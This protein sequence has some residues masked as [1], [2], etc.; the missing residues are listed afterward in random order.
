VQAGWRVAVGEDNITAPGGR[1]ERKERGSMA[2]SE[3][4]LEQCTCPGCDRCKP[5][6]GPCSREAVEEL[7]QRCVP[8]G[9]VFQTVGRNY[10][11]RT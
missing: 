10:T 8:C 3:A 2:M 1:L 7:N 11:T 5:A 6:G 4:V 9:A